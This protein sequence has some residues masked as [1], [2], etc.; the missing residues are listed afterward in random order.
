MKST[1]LCEEFEKPLAA[2]DCIFWTFCIKFEI[3]VPR[4]EEIPNSCEAPLQ[5]D[6]IGS[7][8]LSTADVRRYA[9][10]VSESTGVACDPLGVIIVGIAAPPS[11]TLPKCSHA[12][13]S[14]DITILDTLDLLLSVLL[15]DMSAESAGPDVEAP[16]AP[17]PNIDSCGAS[18]G[19]SDSNAEKFVV[20][21]SSEGIWEL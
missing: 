13:C 14:R 4:F 7:G 5:G 1:E 18:R 17:S 15:R 9:G 6:V 19:L 10:E 11:D 8:L 16:S 21:K 3:S 20:P 2:R 12:N